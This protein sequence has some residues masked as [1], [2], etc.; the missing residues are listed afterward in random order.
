VALRLEPDL[1]ALAGVPTTREHIIIHAPQR[2]IGLTAP[3]TRSSDDLERT[4]G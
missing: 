3:S 2:P 4:A 1:H